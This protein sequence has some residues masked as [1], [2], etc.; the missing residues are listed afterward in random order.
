MLKT[1]KN[2]K[3][4]WFKSLKSDDVSTSAQRHYQVSDERNENEHKCKKCLSNYS[5][6]V[7]CS[8]KTTSDTQ[9]NTVKLKH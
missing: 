6:I 2:L 5:E 9:I 8:E 1:L 3:P 4:S 7:R